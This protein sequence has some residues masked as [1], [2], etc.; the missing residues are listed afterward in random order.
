MRDTPSR[1]STI[2]YIVELLFPLT[3]RAV[4]LNVDVDAMCV[5]FPRQPSI[6]VRGL[7][8]SFGLATAMRHKKSW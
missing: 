7:S 1:L 3:V 8:I 2:V 6:D 5:H 4:I